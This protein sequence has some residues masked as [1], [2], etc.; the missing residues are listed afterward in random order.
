VIEHLL[1]KYDITLLFYNPNI[2]PYDEYIKRKN[3]VIKYIDA[4]SFTSEVKI[5]ECEYD[6]AVFTESA[7][8]LREEPEGGARCRKCFEIRLYETANRASDGRYDIFASTLSVS[9]HK[10][11]AV[12][13]EIG[14]SAAIKYDIAYLPSDFKKNDG[15]KRSTELSKTYGLYRQNYC[16]CQ[17]RQPK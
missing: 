9:P 17:L 13:N 14:L 8:S 16:G 12:I 3:E 5:L 1:P 11:A 4:A 10:N 15:Y 2:E 7:L 6:N